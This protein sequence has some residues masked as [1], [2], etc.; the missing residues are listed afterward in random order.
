MSLRLSPAVV[1]V[2]GISALSLTACGR[3]GKLEAPPSATSSVAQQ[4]TTFDDEASE[5]LLSPVATPQKQ[6]QRPVTVPN[7]PFILD[8]IL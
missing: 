1:F 3:A 8:S 4:Q 6:A 5:N 2:L 7:R